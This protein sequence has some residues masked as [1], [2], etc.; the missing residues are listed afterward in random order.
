MKKIIRDL[1]FILIILIVLTFSYFLYSEIKITICSSDPYCFAKAER[2]TLTRELAL[3]TK[4]FEGD[5]HPVEGGV[6]LTENKSYSTSKG[7]AFWDATFDVKRDDVHILF[8]YQFIN[9][10]DNNYE[11]DALG[12]WIDDEMVFIMHGKLVDTQ[13]ERSVI[14]LSGTDPGEH[15]LTVALHGFGEENAKLFVGNFTVG[16]NKVMARNFRGIL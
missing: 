14:D 12:I 9:P 13:V 6:I 10:G 7:S 8:D 5:A 15:I 3:S 1:I 4:T 16:S 11:G 2:D